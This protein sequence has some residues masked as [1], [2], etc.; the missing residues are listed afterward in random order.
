[1][2]E[3]R[4][5]K[6]QALNVKHINE[7]CSLNVY[8][9]LHFFSLDLSDKSS[10]TCGSVGLS[11]TGLPI[12]IRAT[13]SPKPNDTITFNA[14]FDSGDIERSIKKSLEA[15]RKQYCETD[16]SFQISIDIPKPLRSHIGLG[17]TTQVVGG[18]IAV[19]GSLIGRSMQADEL[20]G[21]GV[22]RV[23]ALGISLLF[24][25]GFI[26]EYG[27]ESFTHPAE[28]CLKHPLFGYYQRLRGSLVCAKDIPWIVIVAIPVEGKSISGDLED[29][30]WSD[31]LPDEEQSSLSIIYY[32]NMY[33]IPALISSDYD[34]FVH[35]ISRAISFGTKPIE[36][37]IQNQDTAY[38][39]RTMRELFGFASV[40]SLGP[41]LFSISNRSD[42]NELCVEL[43]NQYRHY[44]FISF[45]MVQ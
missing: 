34:M 20:F 21:L 35:G 15:F 39:L 17:L 3:S 44:E 27:Y 8:P 23:S 32:L 24:C 43:S 2:L 26:I 29:S 7:Q 5:I 9:R 6:K 28:G 16:Y 38:I 1:M 12:N 36:E 40:S 37:K 4:C 45:N 22:G 41:T 14:S 13:L 31:L 42:I 18:A 30:F 11:L 10:F 25:P 19:C 33:I